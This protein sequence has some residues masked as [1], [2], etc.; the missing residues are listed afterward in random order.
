MLLSVVSFRRMSSCRSLIGL[1]NFFS[2]CANSISTTSVISSYIG[3]SIK[4]TRIGIFLKYQILPLVCFHPCFHLVS[5]TNG[6]ESVFF[7][8]LLRHGLPKYYCGKILLPWVSSIRRA[9]VC[10]RWIDSEHPVCSWDVS[11]N[12]ATHVRNLPPALVGSGESIEVLLS[13]PVHPKSIARLK[14]FFVK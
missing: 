5:W 11:Q 12:C 8:T 13:I 3:L 14:D 4:E 2:S 10:F 9:N 7:S 1:H 6:C